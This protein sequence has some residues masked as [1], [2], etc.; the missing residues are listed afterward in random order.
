MHTF[1]VGSDEAAGAASLQTCLLIVRL[2]EAQEARLAQLS[3]EVHPRE[4]APSCAPMRNFRWQ[5]VFNPMPAIPQRQTDDP[6]GR[7]HRPCI[8]DP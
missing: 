1:I 8:A 4:G 3:P 2:A 7:H 6:A 5:R